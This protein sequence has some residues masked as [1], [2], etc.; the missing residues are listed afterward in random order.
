[1]DIESERVVS[2][3]VTDRSFSE[4]ARLV[5]LYGSAIVA[6]NDKPRYL[7]LDLNQD[8]DAETVSNQEVQEISRRLMKRNRAVYQEL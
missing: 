1:M 7:V 2:L 3:S 8:K 6:L 4:I 5:D